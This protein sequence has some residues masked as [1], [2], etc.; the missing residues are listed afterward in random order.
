MGCPSSSGG[1]GSGIQ[2]FGTWGK[3]GA[4][5]GPS[6][7]T[8]PACRAG[9]KPWGGSEGQQCGMSPGRGTGCAQAPW[10]RASVAA[11][12][13]EPPGRLAQVA[14]RQPRLVLSSQPLCASTPRKLVQRGARGPTGHPDSPEGMCRLQSPGA[15]LGTAPETP[16]SGLP[17]RTAEPARH[18]VADSETAGQGGQGCR[19]PLVGQGPPR[20]RTGLQPRSRPQARAA[21]LLCFYSL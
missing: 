21:S 15:P 6:P 16:E 3:E 11:P 1:L 2:R 13:A 12:G 19:A 20:A 10:A 17:V 8:R 18:E 5:P 7:P 14:G 4:I 9:L